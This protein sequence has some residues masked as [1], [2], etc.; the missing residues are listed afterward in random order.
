LYSESRGAKAAPEPLALAKGV[1]ISFVAIGLFVA[2]IGF[3]IGLDGEAFCTGS[4]MA[5]LC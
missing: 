5:R 1:A 3:E 2:V 4:A